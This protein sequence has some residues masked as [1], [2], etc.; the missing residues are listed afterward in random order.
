MSAVTRIANLRSA[1]KHKRVDAY[2]VPNSDPH[3]SEYLPDHFKSR[4]WLSGFGGSAGTLVVTPNHAALWTDSRYFLQAEE[5]LKGTGIELCKLGMPETPTP[6]NWLVARLPKKSVVA[7][8]GSLFPFAA[9]HATI[10]K[11]NELKI[12][13]N[14]KLDLIGSV[15]ENRPALPK[16]RAFE[17]ELRYTGASVADKIDAIRNELKKCSCHGCAITSLDDVAWTFNIRGSDVEYNPVVLAYG[18]VSADDAILF[19]D[20]EKIDDPLAERLVNQGIDI[21]P[22]NRAVKFFAGLS[23]EERV[24]IDPN[25]T[26]YQI[27]SS[28]KKRNPTTETISIPTLL[29]A[30][31]N[32]VEL[33]NIRQ[34]MVRDGVALTRF[35]V[36]FE[37]NLGKEKMDEHTLG[38]RLREFRSVQ[39]NFVS[40]SFGSIVGYADHGAIVHYSATP[41]TAYEIK[42]KGFLLIDSGGQYLDGTT[43]ITRT[44]HLSEPT[45]QE[46]NDYT[47]VLK[48][49]IQL[50]MAQF[51]AG[52]RGTQLDALARIAMWQQGINYGHGTGHG[53]GAF[54]NVHEGPQSI[55]PNEN[56][57]TL[58]P[59]MVQSN[60]PAI[61]RTG[62]YGIR[63][64][65]LIA[66]VPAAD[67]GYGKFY[68]F[69]TLT[70]CPI[71]TRAIK[72]EML[73]A[74]ERV[75]LNDYHALVFEKLKGKLQP[76]ETEWLRK[77][78]QAI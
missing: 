10:T 60:E 29:K 13:V 12:R 31:K 76:R 6:E 3:L 57:V 71:D 7:F 24:A 38:E 49:M 45:P 63:I 30:R 21:L 20:P 64:E 68:R 53:V 56:P 42:P 58:E 72:V 8:D 54:L 74:E 67:N 65:N 51:P 52:T 44:L 5:E 61:Y 23:R 2:I 46:A 15:W 17:L 62:Q 33:E 69:E 47:L 22:Y 4:Q 27:V 36:W 9:A 50:S 55:R 32:A 25:R 26:N 39:D 18:Y 37:E 35:F 59:G 40:E 1:M 70:L 66:C 34:A 19:I 75:W 14:P 11:L 73:T 48:G 77:K 41:Q 43:D 78:T 28:I 16:G